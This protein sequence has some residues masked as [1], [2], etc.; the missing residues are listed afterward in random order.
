MGM[1]IFLFLS[2]FPVVLFLNPRIEAVSRATEWK[3]FPQE[4]GYQPLSEFGFIGWTDW[5]ITRCWSIKIW[6]IKSYARL[7]TCKLLPG[8]NEGCQKII[9]KSFNPE[10]PNS[11]RGIKVH[12]IVLAKRKYSAKSFRVFSRTAR[13]GFV[14]RCLM[15]PGCKPGESYAGKLLSKYLTQHNVQ[16]T[17]SSFF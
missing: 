13:G 5:W 4:T 7:E 9:L 11:D 8:K 16:K 3:D 14:T 17:G 15:S 2:G 12:C 10:N 1:S 6:H